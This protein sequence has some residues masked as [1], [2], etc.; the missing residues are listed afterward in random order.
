MVVQE[1]SSSPVTG[2][3][4]GSLVGRRFAKTRFPVEAGKVAE[5]SRAV[6]RR[7][8]D[9]EAYDWDTSAGGMV[10]PLT[11]SVA[12]RL[13]ADGDAL[14]T[15]IDMGLDPRR[16]VHGEQEWTYHSP[17]RAGQVL[18]GTPT[19]VEAYAKDGRKGEMVFVLLETA[20]DDE[21]TGE[22]VVTER[23]LSIQLPE[24]PDER[25]PGVLE[26]VPADKDRLRIDEEGPTLLGSR[27]SACGE[28]FFPRR[29][30]CP[31]DLTH[32]EPVDL[33]RSGTIHVATYVAK[34]AYGVDLL[35]AEGY[36]VG[37][38]DLPEG[39]RVQCVLAGQPTEWSPGTTVNLVVE[40]IGQDEEGRTLVIHRFAVP[41]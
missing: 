10:A 14:Q 36:G 20:F 32:V 40:P 18:V 17:M 11:Y 41:V 21:R 1:T 9:G 4:V 33:S 16:V 7:T 19:I 28:S 23:M 31:V 15:V 30:E 22:P 29:W 34:P 38:V 25:E 2:A 3:N 37:Q 8:G 35:D 27:C 12:A 39:V 6:G 24:P 26:I 13:Y 5:F